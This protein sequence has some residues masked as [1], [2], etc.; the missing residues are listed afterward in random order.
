MGSTDMGPFELQPG[1]WNNL[2]WFYGKV[3]ETIARFQMPA[4]VKLKVRYGYG[5][6]GW[7]SQQQTTD[8]VSNR[9]LKVS[10]FVGRARMAA[11]VDRVTL[12]TYQR[13]TVGPDVFVPPP[14]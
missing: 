14:E 13:I 8:G 12:V 2:E 11:K 6:L 7:N 4:G 1:R 10:G 3:P 5:R 9:D